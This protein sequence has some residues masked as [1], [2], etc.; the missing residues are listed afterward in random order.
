MRDT[1]GYLAEAHMARRFG[2]AGK[3]V[4]LQNLANAISRNHPNAVLLVL[5]IFFM[6]IAS[7]VPSASS[8]RRAPRPRA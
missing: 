8:T 4:L 3:T 7:T 2:L 6:S 5:L 1:E